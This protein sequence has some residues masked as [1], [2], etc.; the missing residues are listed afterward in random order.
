MSAPAGVDLRAALLALE[1]TFA[2]LSP[3][4][5]VRLRD[6]Y[7]P[8]ARFR[9]PFNDVHGVESIER[10]FRHMFEQLDGPRFVVLDRAVDAPVAWLT[11]NLEYRLHGHA[12]ARRIHGASRLLF[13]AAGRV[14]E[15]RDYWDA[16][17]ELYESVPV[18][19]A[20]LRRI[21]ARLRTP[22]P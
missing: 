21:R 4:S 12:R 8:Q 20:V 13:D 15:H 2:T 10:I 7:A 5:V 17:E 18:L 11:W 1:S 3:D 22:Q 14:V 6:H 9:D 16:A 19:G